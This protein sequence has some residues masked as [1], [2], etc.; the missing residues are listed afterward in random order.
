MDIGRLSLIPSFA[1]QVGIKYEVDCVVM[2]NIVAE[3]EDSDD[4][5]LA[6]KLKLTNVR[7]VT[8][9]RRGGPKRGS[10]SARQSEALAV[11]DRHPCV[12]VPACET[13]GSQ[14]HL[15]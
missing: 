2:V 1:L 3:G 6:T 11:L 7:H 4:C 5:A 10:P 8:T 13:Y 15:K 12:S 14:S 9:T